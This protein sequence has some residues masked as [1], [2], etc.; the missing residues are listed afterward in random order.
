MGP[1]IIKIMTH[2]Q[3]QMQPWHIFSG[4]FLAF[5]I[6][7]SY[8]DNFIITLI[9]CVGA[10]FAT[11]NLNQFMKGAGKK[12][13]QNFLTSASGGGNTNDF[14]PSKPLP[15]EPLIEDEDEVAAEEIMEEMKIDDRFQ[16]KIIMSEQQTQ[17]VREQIKDALEDHDEGIMEEDDFMEPT[18][19]EPTHASSSS[20]QISTDQN[21]YSQPDLFETSQKITSKDNLITKNEDCD[22]DSEDSI[23]GD[24]KVQQE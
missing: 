14:C 3:F 17:H 20:P 9:L 22:D 16:E 5:W 23:E 12:K 24:F 18:R 6:L 1:I 19:V 21:S 8:F 7:M 10:G 4:V 11:D 15:P 13:R 2:Q